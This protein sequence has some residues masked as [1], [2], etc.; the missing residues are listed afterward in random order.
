VKFFEGRVQIANNF[1][2][3]SFARL[4]LRSLTPHFLLFQ[5]RLSAPLGSRLGQ[6][7]GW[8]APDAGPVWTKKI[9]GAAILKMNFDVKLLSASYVC[10]NIRYFKYRF[11]TSK[12]NY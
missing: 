1:R 11:I 10:V 7:S 2:I 5:C 8:S 9:S 3:N 6:Q 12:A 4:N